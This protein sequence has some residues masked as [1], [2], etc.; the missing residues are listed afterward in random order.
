MQKND[1]N[2]ILEQCFA[3]SGSIHEILCVI[4]LQYALAVYRL[5]PFWEIQCEIAQG[6]FRVTG[7]VGQPIS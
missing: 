3:G 1:T 2:D 6:K 5:D 4:Q 7:E